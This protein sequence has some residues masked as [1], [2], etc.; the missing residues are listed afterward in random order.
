MTSTKSR[1]RNGPRTHPCQTEYSIPVWDTF[2]LLFHQ[3]L[4]D[5]RRQKSCR[6]KDLIVNFRKYAFSRVLGVASAEHCGNPTSCPV[7][8]Y[9]VTT[10]SKTISYLKCHAMHE[11]GGK[12]IPVA[13]S[14]IP[15]GCSTNIPIVS[16]MCT[17]IRGPEEPCPPRR[18]FSNR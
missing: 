15:V 4:A 9:F 8:L 5:S 7:V 3:N 17:L 14:I 2:H 13:P 10:D 1:K 6:R 18:Q 11:T 12:H 16:K